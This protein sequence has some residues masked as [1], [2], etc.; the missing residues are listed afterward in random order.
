MSFYSL[1]VH[2]ASEPHFLTV[3]IF[4][5]DDLNNR[6]HQVIRKREKFEERIATL[7]HMSPFQEVSD[8]KKVMAHRGYLQLT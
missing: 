3:H 6:W 1:Q 8:K 7:E 5:T 2:F 4:G